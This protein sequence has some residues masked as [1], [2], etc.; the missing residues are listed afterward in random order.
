MDVAA[1]GG[2]VEDRV[3]HHLA[4]A[5]VGH[6]AAAAGL[7]DVEAAGRAGRPRGRGRSRRARC[8]PSVKTGSCSSSS[9][10]SGIAPAW[11]SS[12]RRSWSVEPV[13][14]G[15]PSE[16]RDVERGSTRARARPSLH[17]RTR[18]PTRRTPAGPS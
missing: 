7:E 17:G 6:V 4:G 11:R 16:P 14:V 15:D 13:R 2:E 18:A 5:V 3:A 8:G 12:T 9:R 1:V 10:V